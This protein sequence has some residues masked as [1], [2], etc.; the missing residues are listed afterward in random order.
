MVVDIIDIQRV[1]IGEP[2]NH[3]PVGANRY[4]PIAL[5]LAPERM[6][7]KSRQIQIRDHSSGVEPS[8]NVTQF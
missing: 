3:A 6:K 2:K 5:Q 1:A 4:R 8:E 7:P